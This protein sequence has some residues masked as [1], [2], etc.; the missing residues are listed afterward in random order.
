MH[1]RNKVFKG[2]KIKEHYPNNYLENVEFFNFYNKE[3][4]GVIDFKDTKH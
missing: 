1:I 3:S 2:E 4:L